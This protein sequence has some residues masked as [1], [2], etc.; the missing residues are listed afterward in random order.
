MGVTAE[1]PSVVTGSLCLYRANATGDKHSTSNKQ[2][3]SEPVMIR[4]LGTL[5]VGM[6]DGAQA[7]E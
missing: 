4:L 2:H 6:I 5:Y 7:V 3:R 1:W